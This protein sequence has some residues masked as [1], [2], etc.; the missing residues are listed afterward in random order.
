MQNVGGVWLMTSLTTSSLIVALMQTATS[1][2]VFLVVLPAGALADI[3]DRRRM[4]LFTQGW[5]CAAAAGLTGLT[6]LG[7]T[8]SS[9][10]LAFTFALG[11]GAA[12]NVPVWQ[13]VVPGLVSRNELASAVALNSVAFNVARGCGAWAGRRCRRD[14][15]PRPRVSP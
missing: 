9:A 1:L 3:V 10:L 7:A 2:P 11:L 4:L 8:T 6:L 5:M 12:A 15:R 14:C 13:A